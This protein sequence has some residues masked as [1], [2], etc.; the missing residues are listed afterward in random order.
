MNPKILLIRTDI[1]IETCSGSPKP[2]H[3]RDVKALPYAYDAL[4]RWSA[5][6]YTILGLSDQSAIAKDGKDFGVAIEELSYT[7]YCFPTLEAIYFDI[8]VAVGGICRADGISHSCV[9]AVVSRS[10]LG[11]VLPSI[12]SRYEAQSSNVLVTSDLIDDE[13]VASSHGTNFLAG[14]VWRVCL[15]ATLTSDCQP[16]TSYEAF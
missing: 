6:G 1:L 16:L 14:D 8:G 15:D 13:N 3:C 2:L 7:V 11:N 4:A 12:F 10:L 9:D 5:W